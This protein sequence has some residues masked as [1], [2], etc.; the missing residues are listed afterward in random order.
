MTDIEGLSEEEL[1]A[2]G[3]NHSIIHIDWMIGSD[4]IDIDGLKDGARHPLMRAGEW[5]KD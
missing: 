1:I 4:K 5:V 2:R 3:A